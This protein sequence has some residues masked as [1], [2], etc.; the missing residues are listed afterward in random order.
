ML[1]GILVF[2]S[3]LVISMCPYMKELKI[4]ERRVSLTA[5]TIIACRFC[6]YAVYTSPTVEVQFA[7]KA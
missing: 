7:T 3:F 1:D 6:K 2:L 5:L 4:A